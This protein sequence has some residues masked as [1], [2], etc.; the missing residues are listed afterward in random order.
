MGRVT[1]DLLMP[2]NVGQFVARAYIVT[3]DTLY[4]QTES[5]LVSRQPERQYTHHVLTF[6]TANPFYPLFSFGITVSL[7]AK[8][9]RIARIGDTFDAGTT[10]IMTD[11]EFRGTV[12][13]SVEVLG[14]LGTADPIT[15]CENVNNTVDVIISHTGPN[16]FDP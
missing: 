14:Q 10:V 6:S 12:T 2:D 3:K 13:V 7:V 1:V 9:P 8:M 11:P 5:L 4:S 16:P 15:L